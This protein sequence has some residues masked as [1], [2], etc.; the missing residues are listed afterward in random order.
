MTELPIA[1][2]ITDD[3]F[4]EEDETFRMVLSDPVAAGL[5]QAVGTATIIDDDDA[6]TVS[7]EDAP[8]VTEGVDAV[9]AVKLS[10][11]SGQEVTVPYAT[12]DATATA[13]QDYEA[14]V[15]GSL[16]IPAGKTDTTIVVGTS[17]D[18][19]SEE[20]ETFVLTLQDSEGADLAVGGAVGTGTIEDNDEVPTVSIEDAPSVK[21]GVDA[22]FAVKLSVAS[23]REVTVPYATS[24]ATAT[25]GQD[26]EAAVGGSL[27]IPAGKTDTTIVVGTSD[28]V[29]SEETETFVLTL[30]DSEGADLA[31]GGAVGTGTIED[32]DEVPTVSIEDAPS[33]KE[34]VDAVFAVKLSVASGREVTVPYATSDATATAGQ[35]YEAAVGGSLVIPAGKTDT[36]IVV[37]TSDD[38]LSEETETF[39]LTL[40][41]P[42]GADLAVGAAV[43]TGTILDNDDAPTVSIEN[44]DLR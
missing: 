28:D 42:V 16:V 12:S 20:T 8:S 33:V 5:E 41:D 25:A 32:N 30:Q 24:D 23:G 22:V 37:G 43:G 6:P 15:G 31:V 44:A 38:V 18:V 13:G 21:E 29:L 35:D 14:A 2:A 17:D 11:A 3:G 1:V 34:G 10:V 9:F 39:V 40:Q 36:T 7:I 19:L 4:D 27:V 26:Y